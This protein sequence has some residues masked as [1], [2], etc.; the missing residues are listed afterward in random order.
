MIEYK[1]INKYVLTIKHIQ[2][3]YMCVTYI[4]Y[5]QYIYIYTYIWYSKYK[6]N[7]HH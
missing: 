5:M 2:Y 6:T 4:I 1:Y 7:I 3:I